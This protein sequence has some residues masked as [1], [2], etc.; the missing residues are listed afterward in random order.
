MFWKR[1]KK[2]QKISGH[3]VHTGNPNVLLVA[4]NFATEDAVCDA[5]DFMED[6]G[7]AKFK[8]RSIKYPTLEVWVNCSSNSI[9]SDCAKVIADF[10]MVD[11]NNPQENPIEIFGYK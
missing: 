7:K 2:V 8:M 11:L 6:T 3:R 1:K 4:C 9:P 5:L 10:L